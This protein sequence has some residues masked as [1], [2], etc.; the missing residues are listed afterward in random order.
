MS[1]LHRLG[2]ILLLSAA[3]SGCVMT[4]QTDALGNQFVGF[5]EHQI[6][7]EEQAKK[8]PREERLARI[9]EDIKKV[10]YKSV[11]VSNLMDTVTESILSIFKNQS[12]LLSRYAVIVDD[13]KDVMSFIYANQGKS[14]A[15]LAIEAKRFDRLAQH[16]RQKIA[17]KLKRYKRANDEI[18]RQNTILAGEL[19]IQSVR[20]ASFFQENSEE[21]LG[22]DALTMLLNAGKI[23]EAYKLAEIRLHLASIANDFIQDEKAVLEITKKIQEILDEK[24]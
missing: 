19:I 11:Q 15:E 9:A 3:I 5:G 22:A 6:L 18:Q 17:P 8:L 12:E 4:P 21:L 23:S 7:T 1:Q 16:D 24:L 10:G 2:L 13:H 14:K 20:L